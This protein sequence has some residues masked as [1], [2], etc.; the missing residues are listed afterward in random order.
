[1]IELKVVTDAGQDPLEGFKVDFAPRGG[2]S[3]VS[4]TVNEQGIAAAELDEGVYDV[5]VAP[6]EDTSDW[7]PVTFEV[8]VRNSL[9][10]RLT[11][12][13]VQL[14]PNHI[15]LPV[16]ISSIGGV[17]PGMTI[18]LNQI[19]KNFAAVT[20]SNGIAVF[21]LTE[22][23]VDPETVMQIRVSGKSY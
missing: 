10:A 11:P 3:I 21:D 14:S 23:G 20:D 5:T 2:G 12:C 17:L 4:A 13:Q 22:M 1:P 6:P 19:Q 18:S 9:D 8:V 15:L 7:G 16:R